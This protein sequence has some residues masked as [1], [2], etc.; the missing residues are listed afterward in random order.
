MNQ[1]LSV[2][3]VLTKRRMSFGE[4]LDALLVVCPWVLRKDGEIEGMRPYVWFHDEIML[5]PNWLS[6]RL[7][8]SLPSKGWPAFENIGPVF[9]LPSSGWPALG[10]I[11]P[12][13]GPV[14]S[15]RKEVCLPP[16]AGSSG[17]HCG[18]QGRLFVLQIDYSSE[19][20]LMTG[21]FSAIQRCGSLDRLTR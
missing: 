16:P 18:R 10:N 6:R 9:S 15:Y 21:S 11:G 2:P 14:G 8:F 19:G 4:N 20:C 12:S 5:V 1:V 13:G 7:V 17:N 3:T